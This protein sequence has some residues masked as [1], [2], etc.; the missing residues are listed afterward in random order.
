MGQ[1]VLRSLDCS[2]IAKELKQQPKCIIR[3]G[4]IFPLPLPNFTIRQHP[5]SQFLLSILSISLLHSAVTSRPSYLAGKEEELRIKKPRPILLYYSLIVFRYN[6][7]IWLRAIFSVA[8]HFNPLA[9]L[10]VSGPFGPSMIKRLRPDLINKFDALFASE[11]TEEERL[12]KLGEIIPAYL[13]H[14]NAHSP[15]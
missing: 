2:L 13:F 3:K 6:I 10:R 12:S 1:G 5:L 11:L 9:M 4:K 14:C 7:P 15:R 8:R